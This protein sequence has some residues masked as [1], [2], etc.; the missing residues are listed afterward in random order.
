MK[1]LII[2]IVVVVVCVVEGCG[3]IKVNGK[4]LKFFV[5]EIFWVKFYEFIFIFGIENFVV[6]D[7]RIKVVGGG[8]IL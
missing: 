5:F 8:Y 6:I 3:F 7:I 4:F 2:V 1:L